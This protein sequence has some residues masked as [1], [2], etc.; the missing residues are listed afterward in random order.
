MRYFIEVID[1]VSPQLQLLQGL[2]NSE[3][4]QSSLDLVVAHLYDL[5]T[6]HRRN[7]GQR[8][9]LAVIEAKQLDFL[10]LRKEFC[11]FKGHLFAQDSF[12]DQVVELVE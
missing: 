4:S 3:G 9:K 6:I 10:K 8:P 2:E 7:V 1:P 11:V 12:N 5:N